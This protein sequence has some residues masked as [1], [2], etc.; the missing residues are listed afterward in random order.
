MILPKPVGST[1]DQR[2]WRLPHALAG[3][4]VPRGFRKEPSSSSVTSETPQTDAD[5]GYPTGC[6]GSPAGTAGTLGNILGGAL[7]PAIVIRSGESAHGPSSRPYNHY[8]LLAAIQHLWGLPC[9]AN[10]CRIGDADLMLDLFG[11][12]PNRE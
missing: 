3:A 12:F 4:G 10:T 5:G 8:S 7:T 6:F 1:V 2:G 9:L 11:T